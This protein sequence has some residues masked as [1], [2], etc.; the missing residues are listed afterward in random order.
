MMVVGISMIGSLTVLPAAA[1]EARRQGREGQDPV[2][3]TASARQ[4]DNRFWKAS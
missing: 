1:L 3:A 2:P 4:R